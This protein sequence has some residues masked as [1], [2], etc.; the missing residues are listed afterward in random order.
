VRLSNAFQRFST[1]WR[2]L[3]FYERFELIAM[4]FKHSIIRVVAHHTSITLLPLTESW[5]QPAS[6]LVQTVTPH[7]ESVTT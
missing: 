6:G 1:R 4:E 2:V 3:S 5:W 7:G